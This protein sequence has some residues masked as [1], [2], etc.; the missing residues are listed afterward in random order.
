[1]TNSHPNVVAVREAFEAADRGDASKI[2]DLFSDDFTVAAWKI[3]GGQRLLD[4]GEYFQAMAIVGKLDVCKTELV[5]AHTIGDDIVAGVFR[6]DRQLGDIKTV[7]DIL[8]AFRF[9]D[10][11]V[12]RAAEVCSLDFEKFWAATG[13]TE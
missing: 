7:T 4:K 9:K 12:D 10:G 5:D 11:K 1:M 3:E 2:I 6:C 13:I 8:I